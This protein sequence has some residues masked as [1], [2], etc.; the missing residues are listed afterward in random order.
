MAFRQ[1]V[2]IC[3]FSKRKVLKMSLSIDYI[4]IYSYWHYLYSTGVNKKYDM[5]LLQDAFFLETQM[6]CVCD[7]EVEGDRPAVVVLL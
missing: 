1:C 6:Q 4:C 3:E 5:V 7:G 2:T